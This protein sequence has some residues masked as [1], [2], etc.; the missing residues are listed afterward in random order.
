[1][2]AAE[3]CAVLSLSKKVEIINTVEKGDKSHTAI[4]E[5]FGIAKSTVSLLYSKK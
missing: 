5:E 3:K 4:A 2:V 1:M